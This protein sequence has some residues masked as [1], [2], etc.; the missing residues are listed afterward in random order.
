MYQFCDKKSSRLP[1]SGFTLIELLVVVS[2]IALLVSVLLPALSKARG[3]AKRVVCSAN[4]RAIYMAL[5]LY[6]EDY[7]GRYPRHGY[8]V[9]QALYT[10]NQYTFT[11]WR[12][13]SLYDLVVG[14]YVEDVEIFFCPD[15]G[16]NGGVEISWPA[17]SGPWPYDR[18]WGNYSYFGST[19][20][21]ELRIV[22]NYRHCSGNA[23]KTMSR[24]DTVV[25]ADFYQ[26][27][28]DDEPYSHNHRG[29]GGNTLSNGGN[30]D[31]YNY[32]EQL[33]GYFSNSGWP[34]PYN[35][36]RTHRF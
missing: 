9:N 23:H 34:W 3:Q 6:A 17:G 25:A 8:E 5:Q 27:W 36:S 13:G 28:H 19:S 33:Y 35:Y 16:G 15:S 14:D 30:V 31:W 21:L 4:L 20:N 24:P 26:M 29:L 10:F 2:I 7:R 22:G 1:G 32:E 18:F 11:S 12:T